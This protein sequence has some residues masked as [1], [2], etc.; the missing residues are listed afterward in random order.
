[1]TFSRRGFLGL[2]GGVALGAVLGG[3]G[4]ASE[5]PTGQLLRSK[6][7]LPR[8]FTVPLPVPRTATLVG[9]ESGTDRYA[10]TQRR[11]EIEIL[12]GT[13]TPILG[14]DGQFP[15]PTIVSRS[16]RT[17]VVEHTN[18]LDIPVVVHLHGGHTPPASDG[19]PTDYLLP[20]GMHQ[21][22]SGHG[23][24]AGR[25]VAHGSF[26][27]EYPMKQRA[28]TLWYHD[29][30]MDF[31][32]PTVYHGL[33]GFQLIHDAEE[34]ALPLPGG[35]RDVPLMIVDR[36]FEEDG[37]FRY[38]AL[39]P[40][41]LHE[42]GVK[43]HYMAGV[44]GDVVLVNG[45]PWPELEVDAARYRFRILNASNARRYDLRLDPAPAGG[46]AFTQIGSDGGL[47]A[48]PV[49]QDS[50]VTAPAERF[51]VV[52][53]FSAYDVGTVVTMRNALGKGSTKDVMRFRVVR[54]AP[55]DS[56]VPDTLSTIEELD[57]ATAVRT[58]T[59]TFARGDNHGHEEWLINGKPYDPER[60][61]SKP[62]LG[63]VELWRFVTDAHHPIHVHLDSFQVTR[64]GGGGP[65][66]FDS[67]WKDTVDVRPG[68]VVEVA[69]RF[70]DYAGTY[71][72]HCHNL[73]HEDMMMMSNFETL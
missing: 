13:R 58:R 55:D 26:A 57:P 31:T 42:P 24:H 29:H 8:P 18:A 61:D 56:S 37:A 30:R 25:N 10:I 20:K 43:E 33:A 16:G 62:I 52:V 41:M 65:G 28:A 45:A 59:F 51:D 49:G 39:D 38:P 35:D 15:G 7:R 64:R 9:R 67:G 68:E 50:I 73:E 48:R 5:Q 69:V 14:Y 34:D 70:A 21:A 36:A 17:T 60:V 27:Y 53:D 19:F 72:M 4:L 40:T 32:G 11:A 6:A 23:A 22:P 47:L 71:V 2:T 12:P 1:M 44:L 54:K 3:C 63:E 46:K 66:P